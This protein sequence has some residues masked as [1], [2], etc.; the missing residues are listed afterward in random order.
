MNRLQIAQ[1]LL[2]ESVAALES[3]IN[4]TQNS[5]ANSAIKNGTSTAPADAAWGISERL[6][7]D[8]PVSP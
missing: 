8:P 2:A 1:K 7:A 4:Q 5:A 6:L 3:A